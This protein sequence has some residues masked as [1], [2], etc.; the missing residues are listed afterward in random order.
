MGDHGFVVLVYAIVETEKISDFAYLGI[1][2]NC[3]LP[4]CEVRIRLVSEITLAV[5]AQLCRRV[6]RR[7]ERDAEQAELVFQ[8]RIVP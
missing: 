6:V 4:N 2:A 8:F 1:I 5:L 7:V 3:E